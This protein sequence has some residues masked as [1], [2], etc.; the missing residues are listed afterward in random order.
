[1][2]RKTTTS[3]LLAISFC[4]I[5]VLAFGQ[6]QNNLS[7]QANKLGQTLFYIQKMYLD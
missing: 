2:L 3:L 5:S 7:M 6:K 4:L 1:M